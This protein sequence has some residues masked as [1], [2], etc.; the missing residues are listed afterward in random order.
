MKSRQ[1]LLALACALS[2]AG[3][4]SGPDYTRPQVD[5]PAAWTPEAPWRSMQPADATPRGPWW[6]RFG[7][8]QLNALQQQALAGNQTLAIATA[9]L[10]QARAQLN[11]TGAAQAPQVN[12]N[13]RAARSR[14]S[15]NR[16]L[17]NYN[18]P[19]FSTVQ[20]DFALG[21][22]VSYEVD[23]FGR[24]QRS[25]EAAGAAAGQSAADLEN[26][27][28]LLT[29][30]LASNYF[31]LRELDVELDVVRRAIA[32]QRQALEL[33]T[34]RH[35]LGATSGLDMAQQQALLDS[36]LTQI[37]LLGRQRAQYEHAIATLTGTPAPAFSIAPSLSPITPPA[38]PV[39]VPSDV[40]ERRPDIAAAERAMAAANAQIGVAS[41]AYYPSF[42]LQPSYGVDSRNWAT[43]FNAP[44]LL[45]SLGVSASQSLFDGGRL[46][47]GVD[48][49]QAGY[50]ATVAS[51]R[52]T[53]LTAMQEVE[54]GI[55]GLA[56]LERAYAQSQLAIVSAR[57]VLEIA[58][59]RY[60][61]GATPYLD[62]I[63][64]QQSL[65]NSERQAAQLMGQRL[66]VSVFLIKAL[67]GDWQS[68]THPAEAAGAG[69]AR[70]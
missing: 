21:A 46:R 25:V 6:E 32:L 62:V 30:E 23:F 11:V 43:L 61:G 67:G 63:T 15:A 26:T 4:A 7:D 60:E 42:M 65:L 20:N 58:S 3:C 10:A 47:A 36:T 50:E 41:A 54:D 45:W 56:A 2:L 38:I 51:Y 37:D 64:A 13:A 35:D 27:R 57:R 44:S 69:P 48:F 18:S 70:P 34:A 24:V 33:A 19:N 5:M 16:P 14:I 8:A 59:S 55:T 28:L 53:V 49:S 52:R 39:G 40:L 68:R 17:T 29:A 31:N 12:L 9:R 66:L 22:S 1:L